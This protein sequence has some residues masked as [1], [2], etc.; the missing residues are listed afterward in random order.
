MTDSAP[1]GSL[2]KL[3][4]SPSNSFSTK[5]FPNISYHSPYKIAGWELKLQNDFCYVEILHCD[6]WEIDKMPIACKW[7]VVQQKGAKIGAQ[8]Y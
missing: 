5:P 2:Q 4:T 6:Q 1:C 3:I 7:L 8:R